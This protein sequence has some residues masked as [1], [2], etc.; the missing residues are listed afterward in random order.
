MSPPQALPVVVG[1]DGSDTTLTAV[2]WAV[3]HASRGHLTLR[4][5]HAFDWPLIRGSARRGR[6]N[7][8][9]RAEAWTLI[10]RARIQAYAIDPD[11]EVGATLQTSF[12]A[13][14][15]LRESNTASL[16]VVGTHG[17]GS[18]SGLVIGSTGTEL[19][20]RA[21]TPVAVIRGRSADEIDAAA[22]VLVGYDG[23]P[24]S[25]LAV[26]AGFDYAATHGRSVRL[27]HVRQEDAHDVI[28]RMDDLSATWH[29]VHPE[30]EVISR[31][32]GGHPGGELTIASVDAAL[33]VVGSRGL[34]GFRGL[35][36]GSVSQSL[37]HH[38]QCPVMVMPPPLLARQSD[39]EATEM[40]LPSDR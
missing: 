1:V 34:G 5:V 6:W 16:V 36:L 32:V 27:L 3:R 18:L 7:R 13:Q 37:L 25:D 26:A 35:A 24:A 28:H 11:L 2:V 33:I 20:A 15:L 19:A 40:S 30:I 17:H 10:E 29:R 4:I 39:S 12:S 9:L 14:L 21:E 31:A 8:T 38:S 22:P 23:S